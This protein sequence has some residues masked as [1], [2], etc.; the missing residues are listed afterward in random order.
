M[1]IFLINQDHEAAKSLIKKLASNFKD[2]AIIPLT[3]DE[4]RLYNSDD[5]QWLNIGE[6]NQN[7]TKLERGDDHAYLITFNPY[8]T[9]LDDVNRAGTYLHE[10]GI[11]TSFIRVKE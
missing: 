3:A 5:F 7:I 11:N 6:N 1:N 4:M 10:L 8:N 2:G 9:V